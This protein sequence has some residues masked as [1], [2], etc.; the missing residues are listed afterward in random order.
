[1]VAEFHHRAGVQAVPAAGSERIRPPELLTSCSPR[2]AATARVVPL[3]EYTAAPALAPVARI[4]VRAP[5]R[6]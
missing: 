2:S 5:V 4:L 6:L 3:A 1:M